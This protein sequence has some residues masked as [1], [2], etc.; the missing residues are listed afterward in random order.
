MQVPKWDSGG[1]YVN[2]WIEIA[3]LWYNNIS[4][5]GECLYPGFHRIVFY[6]ITIP[7]AFFWGGGGGGESLLED[8]VPPSEHFL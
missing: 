3:M 5:A 4:R 8:F 2:T 7:G 6:T 1:V